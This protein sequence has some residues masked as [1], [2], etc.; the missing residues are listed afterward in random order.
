MQLRARG[1]EMLALYVFRSPT[2]GHAPAY[3]LRAPRATATPDWP[4]TRSRPP[5]LAAT[6]RRGALCTD[7]PDA[8]GRDRRLAQQLPSAT[9]DSGPGPAT[10]GP[11]PATRGEDAPAPD[12]LRRRRGRP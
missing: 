1:G 6:E 10:R 9:S 12:R 7:P 3:S 5:A 2:R 11:K 8:T 4:L